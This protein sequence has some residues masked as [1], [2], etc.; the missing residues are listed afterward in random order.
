MDDLW[1]N[2]WDDS[3]KEEEKSTVN[4]LPTKEVIKAL[5]TPAVDEEPVWHATEQ[6]SWKSESETKAG[7]WGED[8]SPWGATTNSITAGA[9]PPSVSPVSSR[10]HEPPANLPPATLE[11]GIRIPSP[12]QPEL[13][14][15]LPP[16]LPTEDLNT[17]FRPPSPSSLRVASPDGFGSFETGDDLGAD[18]GWASPRLSPRLAEEVAEVAEDPGWGGQSREPKDLRNDA[19]AAAQEEQ[20]RRNKKVVSNNCVVPNEVWNRPPIA[21]SNDKRSY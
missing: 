6:P 2:A 8:Q 14:L 12:E 3:S 9:S 13:E 21:S 19:W 18:A 15:Q 10:G 16:E 1:G 4:A 5:P 20:A 17:H 11:T 7:V